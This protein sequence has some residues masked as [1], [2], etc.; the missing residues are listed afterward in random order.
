MTSNGLSAYLIG[1][2]N[3]EPVKEIVQAKIM[4]DTVSWEKI[5]YNSQVPIAARS[6]HSTVSFQNK[7]FI[8]GGCFQY[9]PH[10]KV[11]ECTNQVLELDINTC[12]IEVVNTKGISIGS[13]KNHTAAAYKDSM[14]V[15]GGQTE[16][17]MVT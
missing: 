11:R 17:G 10:R 6:C 4:G 3:Q 7:L 14:I 1:G 16:N 15:Y 12:N 9:N 8:F 5:S 2:M 13:R